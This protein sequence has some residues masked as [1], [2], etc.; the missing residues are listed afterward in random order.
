MFPRPCELRRTRAFV[1]LVR[2]GRNVRS[3]YVRIGKGTMNGV[4]FAPNASIRYFG[5]RMKC[6]VK[7]GC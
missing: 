2:G 7:R 6:I 3:F 4:K 1:S 5:T